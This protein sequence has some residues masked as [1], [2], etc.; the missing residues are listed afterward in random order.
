[1]KVVY[2]QHSKGCGIACLAMLTDQTYHQV[3]QD[4]YGLI[5]K[6]DGM[7][8]SQ[9]IQYLDSKGFTVSKPIFGWEPDGSA[10]KAWPPK[11]KEPGLLLLVQARVYC[12]SGSHY[13][14]IDDKN[15]FYDPM[16]G[17]T[18]LCLYHAIESVSEVRKK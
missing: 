10:K 16:F 18:K 8:P 14:V 4:L 1:M 15:K 12:D 11:V 6:V 2:Q 13:I 3:Y 17:K 5:G 7:F 9:M